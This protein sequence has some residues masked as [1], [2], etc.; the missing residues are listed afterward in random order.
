MKL[1]LDIL[2]VLAALSAL[3]AS[4]DALSYGTV[5]DTSRGPQW[6]GWTLL[7]CEYV[8]CPIIASQHWWRHAFGTNPFTNIREQEHYAVDKMWHFWWGVSITDY[9]YWLLKRFL[10]K[11]SPWLAMGLTLI[12]LSAVEFLDASDA[13]A[14]WGLSLADQG[15]NMGGIVL[16]YAKYRYPDLPI[17]VRVGFRRWDRVGLYLKRAYNTGS[18]VEEPPDGCSVHMDN[19]SIMKVEVIVRPYNYFYVGIA[20]SLRTNEDGWGMHENLFGITA[21]FDALRWYANKY[22]GK[23]TPTADAFGRHFSESAAYTHW[24]GK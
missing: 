15:A 6:V 16:W 4:N 12:S 22:P 23:L 11:D 1:L 21:G 14:K 24:F 10:G 19:Y 17:D 9:N 3:F 18:L 13:E 5:A 2:F 7:G 20:F 8:I